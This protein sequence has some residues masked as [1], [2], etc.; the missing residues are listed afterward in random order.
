LISTSWWDVVIGWRGVVAITGDSPN[1][2]LKTETSNPFPFCRAGQ[3]MWL[4]FNAF[5]NWWVGKKRP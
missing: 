2:P 3:S 1:V 5:S 4:G